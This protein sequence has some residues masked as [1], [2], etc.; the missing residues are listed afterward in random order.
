[1]NQNGVS[2]TLQ[3]A[4]TQ[5]L[6]YELKV[7]QAM[8]RQVITVEPEDTMEVVRR[9][10]KEHKLSGTPVTRG[11]ELVGIVSI[12]DLIRSLRQG[13]GSQPV[14]PWMSESVTTLYADEPLVH[15]AQKFEQCG[16]G[17]FPVIDRKTKALV[18][19]LTKVDIIHCMLRR[20]EMDFHQQ[21]SRRYRPSD[22]FAELDSN[23]T[24]L[25]LRYHVDGGNF[26]KAGEVSSKL[27]RSLLTLGLSPDTVRRIT[28]ASYEGEMNLVIFTQGGEL[29]AA[30]EPGKVTVTLAD[31]GPG[32]PDIERAMQ[33]GYSTAPDWVRELGFGA[34]M[35]LPN[36]KNCA[37]ELKL[38]SKVG[39]GTNLQFTVLT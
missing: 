27:K 31:N 14:K 1:M 26:E 11:G 35:G 19:I 4:R 20:L 16:Y 36:I 5:E 6:I 8:T 9:I 22:W 10:L 7:E 30:V 37:H 23:R 18:G 28:I 17:R 2:R 33:P 15:A 21:E 34:G 12:E 3:A 39:E 29:A 32:I 24:T 13:N 38:E 25:W